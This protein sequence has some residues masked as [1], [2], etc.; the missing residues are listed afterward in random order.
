MGEAEAEEAGTGCG[1]LAGKAEE[2][3][4]YCTVPRGVTPGGQQPLRKGG[5]WGEGGEEWR[6]EA[7]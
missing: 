5:A 3:G 1:G 7:A 2:M 4:L 6:K